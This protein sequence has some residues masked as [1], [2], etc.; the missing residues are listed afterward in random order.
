VPQA[1][2]DALP[3]DSIELGAY[4]EDAPEPLDDPPRAARAVVVGRLLVAPLW[5]ALAAIAWVAMRFL[6]A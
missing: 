4:G 5:A 3:Q 6:A 2:L 1:G